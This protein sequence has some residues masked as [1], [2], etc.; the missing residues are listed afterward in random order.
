MVSGARIPFN[1][2]PPLILP[3]KEVLTEYQTPKSTLMSIEL[4]KM[5]QTRVL[6]PA[7]PTPSFIS[8]LFIITKTNGKNRV[9]FNL[10]ALNRYLT[11]KHF[12]LINHHQTPN[13]LQSGDWMAKLD[14]SQA[15]YHLPIKVQ[16]RRYLRISYEGK[17]WQMTCLPFGLAAAP[18]MFASLTNWTAEMLRKQGLRLIVYLDDY[19]LAHQ[20]REQLE[21][22]VKIAIKFL[23]SLGWYVNLEKSILTPTRSIEFLGINWDTQINAKSL[24]QEKV[25]KVG[26]YI[27]ARLATGNWTLKQAQRLLG[28]L[29][30][31]TFIT[32]RGRLHCRTLQRHSN[33]LRLNPRAPM[34][35]SEEVHQDLEWWLDN[36]HQVTPIHHEM[37][38]TNYIVTD[39]SDIQWGALVNSKRLQGAWTRQQQSWHCNMKEMYAV[40]AAISAETKNLKDSTV[41]LQSDNR[42][43]IAFIRNEGGT[44]SGPLLELT[45]V[46]LTLVDSLN[47]ILLPHHLPGVYNT[48]ADHLSRKRVAPEW[49]LLPEATEKIFGVWGTPVIDLFASNLAHVVP[50]YVSLDLADSNACFHEAFSRHWHYDLAWIFCPPSL[51]PRVLHHLNSASGRF[52][53]ITPKWK[54]PFWR[55]D[56]KNRSLTRPR[57]IQDL[58][59][60]LI[61]TSTGRPPAQVD[62]LN[63]EAWLILG[64]I[65]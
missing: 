46:L 57:K 48:E 61:D 31:A 21:A 24:P 17:L 9:I 65:R 8:P 12:N 29:N 36:I 13:F 63:L 40:I 54:K 28:Y 50:T 60:N 30:F 45:K 20:S 27:Q 26:Q 16:H 51:L 34:K 52:I 15:Y 38:T 49:H 19:L 33:K 44:R 56:L 41:I 4:Q 64:G 55:P 43:V 59:T 42:T 62:R 25:S 47:I 7:P 32:H 23:T 37:M 11:P 53:I 14:L 1:Q 10:K 3:T 39:A 18:K 6:E 2:A 35:F 22:Q 58:E 5:I